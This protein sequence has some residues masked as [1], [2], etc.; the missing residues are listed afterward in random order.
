MEQVTREH[1]SNLHSKDAS[2]RYLSFQYIMQVTSYPVDWAY[3]VWEDLLALSRNGDNHQRTIAVQ[4]LS[5]LAASDPDQRMSRDLDQL[6]AVTRDKSFVTARH[7]LQSLW[8]VGIV[9]EALKNAIIEKLSRRF[10]QC[11]TE[12]NGTLIRYDILEVFRKIYAQ[13]PD[14]AMP[15]KISALVAQEE[16]VKYRKK[17]AGLWKGLLNDKPA[18]K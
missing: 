13:L 6:L 16:N 8:K 5:N 14:E 15:G 9:N 1:F 10:L 17:Y 18:A 3:E 7:S 11:S 4:V 12:K 2:S